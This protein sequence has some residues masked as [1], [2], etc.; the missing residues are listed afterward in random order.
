MSGLDESEYRKL[1]GI[2]ADTEKDMV[3][4]KIPAG[5]IMANFVMNIRQR[6]GVLEHEADALHNQNKKDKSGK[7]EASIV[8]M[9]EHEIRLNAAEKQ[10]Y[11]GFLEKEYF[12]RDDIGD[13]NAFYA[14]EGAWDKLTKEGKAEMSKR[15]WEG[16]ARGEL[17]FGELSSTT[18][19]K[20]ADYLYKQFTNPEQAPEHINKFSKEA[21]ENFIRAYE[22]GN[23]GKAQEILSGEG[24]FEY[25][26]QVDTQAASERSAEADGE[27]D[28]VAPKKSYDLSGIDSGM[29][30]GLSDAKE[31][32]K[33]DL[34]KANGENTPSLPS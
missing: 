12:T 1:S 31:A 28:K 10:A 15:L 30:A 25:Q 20:E 2:V 11:A 33:P 24:L 6:M 8:A 13:I 4:G 27:A 16:I 9:V 18:R 32:V 3:D 29:L 26:Q 23:H 14:D 17:T 19:Q 5:G 7:M 22:A 21:R 34:P